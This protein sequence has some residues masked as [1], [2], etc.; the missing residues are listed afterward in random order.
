MTSDGAA[1]CRQSLLSCSTS[2][3]RHQA[4]VTAKQLRQQLLQLSSNW[5]RCRKKQRPKQQSSYRMLLNRCAAQQ[6]PCSCRTTTRASSVHLFC[7]HCRPPINTVHSNCL[8][9]DLVPTI[10]HM[11]RIYNVVICHALL[12]QAAAA[13]AQ[14][15]REVSSLQ[16]QLSALQRQHKQLQGKSAQHARDLRE[17]T[18][19]AKAARCQQQV[20]QGELQELRKQLQGKAAAL[21]RWG[22]SG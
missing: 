3:Q 22:A 15:S 12:F 1:A 17:A 19:S 14:H 6:P 8:S 21:S 13:S 18:G 20:L 7:R 2:C 9:R 10:L 4:L 11:Y 5:R 16:A